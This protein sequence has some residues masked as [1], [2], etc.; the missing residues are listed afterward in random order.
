MEAVSG[1]L[2]L[3]TITV[4]AGQIEQRLGDGLPK[5]VYEPLKHDWDE[6][7]KTATAAAAKVIRAAQVAGVIPPE[8]KKSK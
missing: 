1:I 6:S 3:H 2:K 7:V 4:I 5:T 8:K